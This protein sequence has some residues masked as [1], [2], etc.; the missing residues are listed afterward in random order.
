M[1]SNA[2][3]I[4]ETVLLEVAWV[5]RSVYGST[6]EQIHAE[7]LSLLGLA[8]VRVADPLR[9]KQAL[10]WYA[11]GLDFADSLHLAG[12]QHA[13]CFLTFDKQ[14]IRRATGKGVCPVQDAAAR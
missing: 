10:E 3:F 9:I 12:A 1:E 4:P 5:L 14:L 13:D 2:C 6:R 7:L 11:E 8:S